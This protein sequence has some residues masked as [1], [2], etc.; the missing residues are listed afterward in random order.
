MSIFKLEKRVYYNH[1]DAQG[2]VYYSRYLDFCEQC[3][4]E[5]LRDKGLEQNKL[6]NEFN[7]CFVVKDCFV[8]YKGS[9]RLDDL[10]E[11]RINKIETKQFLIEIEQGVYL[12]DKLLTNIKVT[13]VAV[14]SNS[15]KLIRKIPE[16][17][18]N[19]FSSI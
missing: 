9:A 2:I 14:E 12:N 10:V 19:K 7:I 1:T 17:I 4:T 16:N 3:R 8:E 15:F 5:F 6:M 13:L 11:I 18:L